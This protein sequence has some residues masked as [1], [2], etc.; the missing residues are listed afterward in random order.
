MVESQTM[1]YLSDDRL[2][3]MTPHQRSLYFNE[4]ASHMVHGWSK[5]ELVN[6]IAGFIEMRFDHADTKKTANS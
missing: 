1:P 3:N 6:L 5:D 2:L 4:V